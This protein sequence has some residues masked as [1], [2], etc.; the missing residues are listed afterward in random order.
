M[1]KIVCILFAVGNAGCA[2]LGSHESGAF[3]P[4]RRG[5][6]AIGE[7]TLPAVDLEALRHWDCRRYLSVFKPSGFAS[8]D[9]QKLNIADFSVKT[10][11]DGYPEVLDLTLEEL[12]SGG[13][14]AREIFRRA[15]DRPWVADLALFPVPRRILREALVEQAFERDWPGWSRRS[16]EMFRSR[17]EADWKLAAET[18]SK[19]KKH[20]EG[21][22]RTDLTSEAT[23]HALC[24]FHGRIWEVPSCVSSIKQ[25]LSDMMPTNTGME[26]ITLIDE[27]TEFLSD[28]R[29]YAVLLTINHELDA[30]IQGLRRS[31]ELEG[32]LD[33]FQVVERSYRSH[34]FSGK[35]AYDR[36]WKFLGIYST[37][38]G[39][40]ASRAA[41][42]LGNS[43]HEYRI[44]DLLS[45]F[46]VSSGVLDAELFFRGRAL[47]SLPS[48][49]QSTVHTG[50]PYHFWMSAYL[51]RK[52]VL[53]DRTEGGAATAAWLAQIGYQM[54]STTVG[55][56]PKR[57]LVTP[58]YGVANNKI[59]L[60]L[61]AASNGAVFGSRSA[62]ALSAG[63]YSVDDTLRTLLAS[64]E[65]LS[66]LDEKAAAALVEANGFGLW[67]RWTDIFSPYEAFR[68]I[69]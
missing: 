43:L 25:I 7:S 49:V 68:S 52:N 66:P 64:G 17:G 45:L 35:E 9:L 34:G 18:L 41:Q 42:L 46:A 12:I 60:D 67:N 26:P 58:A 31:E 56:D 29:N 63:R 32:G 47:F 33:L 37:S 62:N 20:F 5:P 53:L 10:A 15:A 28:A 44:S 51:A 55:R 23:F 13:P 22:R 57:A 61:A 65:D 1:R 27:F 69:E 38:G 14:K 36:A 40:I 21:R 6:A 50:K 39:N 16:E 30:I 8:S 2:T 3:S 48:G 19:R 11:I 4:T 54:K 59:R 24:G